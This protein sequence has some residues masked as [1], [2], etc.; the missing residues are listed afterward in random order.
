MEP[1]EIKITAVEYFQMN[2]SEEKKAR[3]GGPFV[4]KL[5]SEVSLLIEAPFREEE[6]V[7]DVK[8]CNS[9]K[10]PRLDRFNFSFIKKAGILLKTKCCNSSHN[11]MPMP[12]YQRYQLNFC[13]F[14]F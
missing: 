6:I 12:S 10:V 13:G 7:A 14:D 9:S 3:P 8:G 11:S 1:E 4:R 2:F 5:S